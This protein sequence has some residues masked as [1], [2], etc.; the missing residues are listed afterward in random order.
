MRNLFHWS[1]WWCVFSP[2]RVNG[3]TEA[4]FG[5]EDVWKPNR[6][7]NGCNGSFQNPAKRSLEFTRSDDC[8]KME[9][10]CG[11]GPVLSEAKV[12][13]NAHALVQASRWPPRYWT[14]IFI[15]S[16]L[17]MKPA[18]SAGTEEG[19]GGCFHFA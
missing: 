13:R 15:R 9:L 16:M 1:W 2:L 3:N 17:V 10:D 11:T 6:L 14:Y 5:F 18:L 19:S 8:K 12:P 4:K 7:P